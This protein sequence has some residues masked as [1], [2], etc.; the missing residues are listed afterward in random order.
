MAKF[1][2]HIGDG[3]CGS[4]SMQAALFDARDRLRE[5]GLAYASHHRTSGNFCFGTLLGKNTRGNAE[6][7]RGFA[8]QAIKTLQSQLDHSDYIIISS[9]AFLTLDPE[10]VVEIL[11]FITLDIERIDV[12]AYVRNPLGMY[13]SMAQQLIKSS[14]RFPRPDTYVRS[15]DRMLDNWNSFPMISS[16]TVRMFD[17]NSLVGGNAVADFEHVVKSLTGKDLGLEHINEN[18]SLSTEQMVVLQDYRAQFCRDSDGK[19]IPPSTR[20]IDFFAMMNESGMVGTKAVLSPPAAALVGNNN[21]D[22][23]ERLNKRHGFAMRCPRPTPE[24]LPPANT[25]WSRI[26]SIL[27]EVK[28]AYVHNLKM[29]VPAFNPALKDGDMD[30]GL[31]ALNKLVEMEPDKKSAIERA[32]KN[33]WTT[34]SL[35]GM[36]AN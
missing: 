15:L 10:E 2:V 20:L 34:E 21:A 9:E 1:I 22:I 19:M 36:I 33:Y 30:K 7:Q 27:T 26:S 17:R 29:L 5:M 35:A 28:P 25:D 8:L 6:Q 3:K 18:S 23:V 4:S 12:I 11:Q 31:R 13:L 24:D 32:T 14:H 16:V